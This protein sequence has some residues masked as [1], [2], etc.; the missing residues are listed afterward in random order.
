MIE[1]RRIEATILKQV[2]DA[3]KTNHGVEVAKN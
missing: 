2:Y 3:L 1:R